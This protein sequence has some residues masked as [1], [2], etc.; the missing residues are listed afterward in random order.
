MGLEM[1][2]SRETGG[3]SEYCNGSMVRSS[4][5]VGVVRL[6]TRR[7]RLTFIILIFTHLIIF[8]FVFSLFIVVLVLVLVLIAVL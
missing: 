1:A 3:A 4:Q 2:S 7:G 6:Q 8:G 5:L